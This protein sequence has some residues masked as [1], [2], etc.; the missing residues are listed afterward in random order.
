MIVSNDNNALQIKLDNL[1][2]LFIRNPNGKNINEEYMNI[3]LITENKVIT[4]KIQ[5]LREDILEIEADR[6]GT[7]STGSR[8]LAIENR[9]LQLRK[10]FLKK[11]E[12]ELLELL[13][14]NK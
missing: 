11:R 1:E 12:E 10:E 6:E 7:T 4:G 9:H 3:N 8:Q 2:D 5:Q 13:K 14:K